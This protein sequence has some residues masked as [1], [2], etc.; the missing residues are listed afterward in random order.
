MKGE[1]KGE[2]NWIYTQKE[3]YYTMVKQRRCPELC[4]P[5][6]GGGVESKRAPTAASPCIFGAMV[7]DSA[8]PR[9]RR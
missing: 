8:V 4:S 5:A 2:R 3:V 1:Y 6:L 7:T 9:G